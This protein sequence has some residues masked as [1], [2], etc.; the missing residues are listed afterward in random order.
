VQSI[1]EL[2]LISVGQAVC[3]HDS[4]PFQPCGPIL[5]L[6]N[7]IPCLHPCKCP[8]LPTASIASLLDGAP[9]D[10]PSSTSGK[11]NPLCR[12]NQHTVCYTSTADSFYP[13]PTS[14]NHFVSGQSWPATCSQ[15]VLAPCYLYADCTFRMC[16]VK[17]KAPDPKG[18]YRLCGNDYRIKAIW[19]SLSCF[20]LERLVSQCLCRLWFCR[21]WL[22]NTKVSLPRPCTA[23]Y[24]G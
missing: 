1:W 24:Q 8:A 18:S 6:G 14:H 20:V 21:G 13:L 16:G 7:L 23:S 19:V 3:W 4:F 2:K 10:K 11:S 5:T 12:N 9:N 22:W 15:P 17:T